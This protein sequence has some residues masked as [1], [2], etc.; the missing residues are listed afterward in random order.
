MLCFTE[1]LGNYMR[2]V[3]NSV[4]K[5]SLWKHHQ[6]AQLQYRIHADLISH[7]VQISPRNWL[8]HTRVVVFV[9]N[10]EALSKLGVQSN[11]NSEIKN[12]FLHIGF[13]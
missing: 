3:F 9:V 1:F 8:R 7:A 10:E 2:E 6:F 13:F 5:S 12:P 11:D 4:Q